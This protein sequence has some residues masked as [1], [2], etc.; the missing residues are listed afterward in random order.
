MLFLSSL[1]RHLFLI[2]QSSLANIYIYINLRSH[3]VKAWLRIQFLFDFSNTIALAYIPRKIKKANKP[4]CQ[5]SP[6]RLTAQKYQWRV[7]W[8]NRSI[9]ARP[10]TLPPKKD[11]ERS[12]FS[13]IRQA[14]RFAFALSEPYKTNAATDMTAKTIPK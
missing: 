11:T 13:E 14:P 2:A 4:A 5:K 7:L 12:T 1:K 6:K 9:P 3:V 8:R 10:P